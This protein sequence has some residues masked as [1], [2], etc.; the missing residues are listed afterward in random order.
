V[1]EPVISKILEIVG[2]K[3]KKLQRERG[4]QYRD[5]GNE[6]DAARIHFSPTPQ[7]QGYF[8]ALHRQI[9][10]QYLDIGCGFFLVIQKNS[11]CYFL[12]F[13]R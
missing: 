6:F 9:P 4:R 13:L 12:K 7:G 5:I 2:D 8:F 1:I 3:M 10:Y 11:D